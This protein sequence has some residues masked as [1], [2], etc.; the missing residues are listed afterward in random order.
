MGGNSDEVLESL[1]TVG[2]GVIH[3]HDEGGDRVSLDHLGQNPFIFFQGLFCDSGSGGLFFKLSDSSFQFLIGRLAGHE[4]NPPHPKKKVKVPMVPCRAS[5]RRR[6]KRLRALCGSPGAKHN[7]ITGIFKS[8]SQKSL[9]DLM[10]ALSL[11]EE[12][13]H[14]DFHGC[15]SH[16]QML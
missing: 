5:R 9:K 6:V 2:D 11:E 15:R 12:E 3:V 13:T 1:V 4:Q 14:G 16:R 8:Q 10:A 7:D